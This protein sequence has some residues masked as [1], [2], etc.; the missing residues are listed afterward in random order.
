VD[1]NRAKPTRQPDKRQRRRTTSRGAPAPTNVPDES[2]WI[3]T[4]ISPVSIESNRRLGRGGRIRQK[5][6]S[7]RG[8]G[9]EAEPFLDLGH[10]R[11]AVSSTNATSASRSALRSEKATVRSLPA[12]ASFVSIRLASG[13]RTFES[14]TL[15]V[16][17]AAVL[18]FGTRERQHRSGHESRANRATEDERTSEPARLDQDARPNSVTALSCGSRHPVAS[19]HTCVAGL[20]LVAS[21]CPSSC[22]L[23]WSPS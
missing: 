23:S 11:L 4:I 6:L 21:D 14:A 15:S 1:G 9:R 22:F 5:E 19:N 18:A 2:A 3:V 20:A 12:S 10:E 16:H 8:C 17:R 13:A 7:R